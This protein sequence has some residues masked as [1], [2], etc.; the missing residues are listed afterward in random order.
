MLCN[1]DRPLDPFIIMGIV[2]SAIGTLR[3]V[4]AE[5][6]DILARYQRISA[7]I[8]QD[9]GIPVPNPTRSFWMHPLAS[10]PDPSSD[11]PANA[12]V[13]IIGSGITAAS[14]ARTL[15]AN[16]GELVVVVLEA[17]DA[18][19]GAS[20]PLPTLWT[21]DDRF[22]QV[23]QDAMVA[24]SSAQPCAVMRVAD[25][26]APACRPNL[27]EDYGHLKRKVGA[28]A[29]QKVIRFRQA[30]LSETIKLAED[31]DVLESS[32]ARQVQ[33]LD[34]YYDATVFE[35]YRQRFMEWRNYMPEES[36]GFEVYEGEQARSV[37]RSCPARQ[38]LIA[39][40]EISPRGPLRRCH[41]RSCRSAAPL[42]RH[43]CRLEAPPGRTSG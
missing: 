35:D 6:Q 26:H 25:R 27:Y 36:V 34:V 40:T 2:L 11:A 43:H 33:S 28:A 31:E 32:G 7:R 39:L 9:P 20:R 21:A 12:D 23:Q 17:R 30:H 37:S 15:L 8:D 16:D 5:L 41:C 22:R 10:L 42:P 18:C 4:F 1:R 13:V 14:V 24:I 38:P 29:A 3:A 19:G